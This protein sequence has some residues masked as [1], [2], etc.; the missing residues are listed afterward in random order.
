MSPEAERSHKS[1]ILH[2][3]SN[4]TVRALSDSVEIVAPPLEVFE[5][6]LHLDEHYREWHPD[7]VQWRYLDRTPDLV[8]SVVEYEERLHGS[9]HR[10]RARFTRVVRPGRIEFKNLFPASLICPRGSFIVEPK[11]EG[12]LF[13]ATLEFRLAGLLER[14]AGDRTE[15]MRVH[16]REEGENLKRLLEGDRQER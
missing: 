16:M 15:A 13:T 14:L 9:T 8:G 5:W 2:P 12:S 7:H 3:S 11:G 10:L 4:A 6:L 1:L